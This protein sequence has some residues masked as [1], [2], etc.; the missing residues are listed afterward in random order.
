MNPTYRLTLHAAVKNSLPAAEFALQRSRRTTLAQ[1]IALALSSSTAFAAPALT[2]LP[3]GGQITSGR[4]G[5]AVDGSHMDV[6]Q[7]SQNASLNWQTFNVGRNA[8]VEFH[9]PN[10]SSVAVNRIA[11]PDGSQIMGRVDANGQVYLINPNGVLFGKDAQVNV[12]GLV[13]STLDIADADAASGK[14]TFSS[15]PL[16]AEEGPGVRANG[17]EASVINQGTIT[18]SDGGYAALLGG[19]V[20][21]QGTIA[22][23]LGTV[24]LAAG[25]QVTLDFAGDKLLGVQVDKGALQALAENKQLIQAEG[26]TVLLTARAADSLIQAV[27]NNT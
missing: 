9:Q 1:A 20:S 17:D 19:R 11:D 21:N 25:D 27:V 4:A 10:A 8:E 23:R 13:A 24:A 14:R 6:N 15:S 3:S 7:T 12:G 22:A 2:E 26:G 18:T 16:P 5:I